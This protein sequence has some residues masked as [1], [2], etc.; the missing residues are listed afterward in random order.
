MRAEIRRREWNG[1]R[2]SFL[3]ESCR[4]KDG[5]AAG[6]GV[7]KGT[8]ETSVRQSNF[9]LLR[10]IAMVII[11][12]GHFG[13]HS[14]FDFPSDRITMNRLWIEFFEIGGNISVNVFVLL[15]GYFLIKSESSRTKK[16]IQL[17][18]Q[19]FFYSLIIYFVFV[20]AGKD[21]LAFGEIIRRVLPVSFVQ[22]WFASTYF[23]LALFSPYLNS[24][25]KSFGRKQY[26]G[27]LALMCFCW[28]IMPTVTGQAFEGNF[29][30]WFAFLYALGGYIRLY[31]L[32]ASLSAGK[33]IALSLLCVILTYLTVVILDF[34]SLKHEYLRSKTFYFYEI[35]RI[36]LLVISVLLFCGFARLRIR[37][38]RW[39][40]T[41]ASAM[42][43]VY[44]IHD[45]AYVRYYLWLDLFHNR[46]HGGDPLLILRFAG[47]VL[48]V[49]AGCTLIEL[50]RIHLLEKKYM[51]AVSRLAERI[52]R[53]AG[54]LFTEQPP[55]INERSSGQTGDTSRVKASTGCSGQ[56]S[57][58]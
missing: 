51:P 37:S 52:D 19:L 15:S 31:G 14:G 49:M 11:V 20:I 23:V 24:L 17:W 50:A 54:S 8:G 48:L 45:H 7:S 41:L 13:S 56:R 39:I 35:R 9:E 28:S 38:S 18:L 29:L 58:E 26:L 3:A 27:L 30:L 1:M 40:N 33:L 22:W 47:E 32:P 6:S 55:Q 12:A 2:T 46:D 21:P 57:A 4:K 34:L 36:P 5:Y 43:G 44:L 53:K 25:L 16:L 42:F 10:M